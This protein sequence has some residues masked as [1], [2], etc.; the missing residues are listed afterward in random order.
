MPGTAEDVQNTPEKKQSSLNIYARLLFLGCPS[1]KP[2]AQM[3]KRLLIILVVLCQ[4]LLILDEP[5]YASA[6]PG[7]WSQTCFLTGENTFG[8]PSTHQDVD[9]HD[10]WGTPGDW[11]FQDMPENDEDDA[12]RHHAEAKTSGMYWLHNSSP[13]ADHSH[14]PCSSLS[15]EI[16]KPPPERLS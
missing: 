14:A 5:A 1:N 15:R 7:V 3:V 13:F 10:Q 8:Y 16:H 6:G 11:D 2:P 9:R 12:L 4:G